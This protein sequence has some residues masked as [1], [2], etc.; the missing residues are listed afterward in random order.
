M[1]PAPHHNISQLN[2]L[3]KIMLKVIRAVFPTMQAGKIYSHW[4]RYYRNNNN[5]QL[6]DLT[7]EL[8]IHF[9]WD[10]TTEQSFYNALLC[11]FPE[12]DNSVTDVT[13]QT[14]KPARTEADIVFCCLYKEL[15]QRV[16]HISTTSC[17]EIREI[18][19]EQIEE[20]SIDL[21]ADA[22]IR[23]WQTRKD[24]QEPP[25]LLNLERR[26]RFI[27]FLYIAICEELGPSVADQILNQARHK[28][29]NMNYAYS[30]DQFL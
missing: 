27:H 2:N 29:L 7:Q 12:S 5:L 24:N 19:I 28:I 23:Y 1:S 3:N 30:V 11:Y 8:A 13:Q 18:I 10:L 14:I 6:T 9:D 4:Y 22:I 16:D 15:M 21:K 26:A 20:E 25:A 17:D